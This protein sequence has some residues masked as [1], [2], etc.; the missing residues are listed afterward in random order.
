MTMTD[1]FAA[2]LGLPAPGPPGVASLLGLE[3]EYRVRRD[4]E[5]VDFRDLIHSLAVP[6]RRLDPGDDNAYRCTSGLALT[7]DDEEAEVASPP[8]PLAP[9]FTAALDG[10][11]RA[12]HGLLERILPPGS[13]PEGYSTHLSAAV[14]DAEAEVVAER[15]ARTFAP[16]LM[17]VADRP[18]SHGIF[19]RPRPSRFEAC[20]EYVIGERLQAAAALFAGGTRACSSGGWE[21]PPELTV[22]TVPASGR[23]GLELDSRVAFGSGFYAGGRRSLLPLAAGGTIA[24]QDHLELAWQAARAALGVH[25]GP[26]DLDTVERILAGSSPLGVETTADGDFQ[27]GL[28]PPPPASPYGGLLARRSRPGYG[29]TPLLATWSYTVF[30]LANAAREGY[31][32]VPRRHLPRFLAL[33]DGGMLDTVLGSYLHAAPSG[34]VLGDFDQTEEPGLWDEIGVPTDLLPREREQLRDPDDPHHPAK[35]GRSRLMG[36]A[37]LPAV[38]GGQG[39]GQAVPPSPSAG[40]PGPRWGKAWTPAASPSALGRHGPGVR[41]AGGRWAKPP[42]TRGPG[43]RRAAVDPATS[44]AGAQILAGRYG[45]PPR[46]ASEPRPLL[47]IAASGPAGGPP[48]PPP[49]P[50]LASA[51][52][53]RRLR[54]RA[55]AWAV[56][57]AMVLAGVAGLAQASWRSGSSPQIVAVTVPVPV[58]AAPLVTSTVPYP[59]TAPEE[60]AAASEPDEPEAADSPTTEMPPTVPP[61]GNTVPSSVP[62]GVLPTQPPT[63]QSAA[64]AATTQPATTQPAT[65]QPATTE[66]PTTDP[67]TTTT[68]P[69]TTTTAAPTRTLVNVFDGCSFSPSALSLPLGSSVRF[70]NQAEVSIVLNVAGPPGSGDAFFSLEP[71]GSSGLYLLEVI[72]TYSFQCSGSG[73]GSMAISVT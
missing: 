43:S 52:V 28:W 20:G 51:S 65:T 70:T 27:C 15:F 44:R 46:V 42:G 18:G 4:G 2:A 69:S 71:G 22:A 13:V 23:C 58:E 37:P 7:C 48:V 1:A 39:Q 45:K 63:T 72:G 56:L 55:C 17:L 34:L 53:P 36:I 57:F 25:A 29:V 26:E 6:G 14:P 40:R 21:L 19:L 73:T 16:A 5:P 60:P 38:V 3:H 12:G 49:T 54:G 61:P 59:T 68:A 41:G 67:P 47:P 66:P 11:A 8:V 64:P 50:P 35:A 33:L 31:A 62:V 30:S 24:A 9:N 32:C 10:W